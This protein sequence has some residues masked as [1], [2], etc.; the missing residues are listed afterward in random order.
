MVCNLRPGPKWVVGIVRKKTG[1]LS[2]VV[3]TD[4]KQVWRRHVDHLKIFGDVNVTEPNDGELES[5][6]YVHFPTPTEDTEPEG[7]NVVEPPKS[8]DQNNSTVDES[9]HT[10]R[11]YP[12][13]TRNRKPPERLG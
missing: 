8:G 4:Y 3:E 12:T 13:C 6:S 10:Q 2:Y 7:D 1:P 11:R 5:D 9:P